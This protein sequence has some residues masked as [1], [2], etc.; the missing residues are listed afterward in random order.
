M[1]LT[2]KQNQIIKQALK[3]ARIQPKKFLDCDSI[4]DWI[5][6]YY[7]ASRRELKA[8]LKTNQSGCNSKSKRNIVD[9]VN[10]LLS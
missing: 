9:A 5:D 1:K 3:D 8:V 4:Q 2:S 10:S 6:Y 7:G